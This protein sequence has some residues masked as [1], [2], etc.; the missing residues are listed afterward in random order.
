MKPLSFATYFP[1][2]FIAPSLVEAL[3]LC[4]RRVILYQPVGSGIIDGL[5]PWIAQGF[6]DIRIPFEDVIDKRD[7]RAELQDWREW[8]LLNQ[9]ADMAYLKTIGNQIAPVDPLT[10]QIASQMKATP[11]KG[12][13]KFENKA[14][15]LQLFLHL[16]QD[17][18]QQS[19]ELQQHLNRFKLQ[20]EA[21]QSFFRTDKTEESD[22]LV[23][24]EPLPGREEDPGDFMIEKRMTAWN[25]LF[26]KD[27]AESSLLFTDSPSAHASLL[28]TVR[29]KVEVFKFDISY[30]QS[31]PDQIPWKDPLEKLFDAVLTKPWSEQLPEW[32]GQET[33]QIEAMI[34]QW[35]K[36]TR[37]PHKKIASFRWYLVPGQGACSLL[38]RRFSANGVSEE[39]EGA[40]NTLVGLVQHMPPFFI[41]SQKI[42]KKA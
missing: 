23:P 3:S 12:P 10:P 11:G 36:S 29:E 13:K 20:H 22:D 18:D 17:F 42:T 34:N 26:Q 9:G 15:S 35:E 7:L 38:N 40:R 19:W 39:K 21:L 27:S 8:G 28:G 37:K 16:A 4:F 1:F 30:A 6:L 24:G 33:R 25:Q 5:Q 41:S 14:L 2:T 32:V 31:P